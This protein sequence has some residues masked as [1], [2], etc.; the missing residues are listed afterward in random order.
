MRQTWLSFRS[1]PQC[2]PGVVVFFADGKRRLI[3]DINK[4]G[5]LCDDCP[6][7]E[8]AIV[9][10]V[11]DARAAIEAAVAADKEGR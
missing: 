10:R 6:I 8:D 4:L 7:P 2:A 5:G 3:G 9:V 1:T 11:V